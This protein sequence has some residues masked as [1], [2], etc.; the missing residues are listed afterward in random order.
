MTVCE[1]GACYGAANMVGDADARS[2]SRAHAEKDPA[3]KAGAEK[4][5][6]AVEFGVGIGIDIKP[7]RI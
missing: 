6:L 2:V 7:R 3:E 5:G 4:D 1:E